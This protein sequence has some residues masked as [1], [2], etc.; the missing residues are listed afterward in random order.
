MV[1]GVYTANTCRVRG[2]SPYTVQNEH[3]MKNHNDTFE[4]CSL[5]SFKEWF[6][7]MNLPITDTLRF[8]TTMLVLAREE[9]AIESGI[10]GVL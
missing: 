6:K 3:R 2:L 7:S 10:S 4:Y 9:L 8:D 1:W 5:I